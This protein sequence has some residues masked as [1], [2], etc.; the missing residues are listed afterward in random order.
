MQCILTALKA[1]SHPLINHFNLKCDTSF[2]F[3]VFK[4]NNL[5][6]VGLG[7]GKKNIRNRIE[8]FLNQNNPDLI[9]FINIGIAGGNPKSTKI[10]GSYLLHKIKDETTGKTYYPDILI[11]HNF[12]EISLVTVE[13][14]ISDGEGVYNGLVDME[15]S[16]IFKICSSLV[17]V[18]RLA[19]LKIVSDYMNNEFEQNIVHSISK[20]I[21]HQLNSIE[22]FLSQ[23]ER[24][25]NEEA[26][27]LSE[28][29]IKWINETV[30]Q[31][32]LTETQYQQLLQFAKGFR[33][34]KTGLPFPDVEK[35]PPSNKTTQKYHFNNICAELSA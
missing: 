33:L 22:S 16:E 34:R 25:F 20:L 29:D 28:K 8:T 23:F 13:S 15:A 11:K 26:P 31:M 4:N 6:L 27:I 21:S 17:P 3:P 12:E 18:H 24:M 14:V 5:Y 1:E 35:N 2:Q 32:S 19:F 7:V 9:Q 30:Q 10:G